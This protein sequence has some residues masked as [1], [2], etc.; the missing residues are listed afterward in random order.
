MKKQLRFFLGLFIF[1]FL[2]LLLITG[3]QAQSQYKAFYLLKPPG[4]CTEPPIITCPSDF[5]SCLTADDTA[6]GNL[7]HKT[8]VL[9]YMNNS[10]DE[11][12]LSF[13]KA[14]LIREKKITDSVEPLLNT[15]N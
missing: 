11:A 8:G 3:I 2:F 9:Y 12:I 1:H 10:Y 14:L 15:L 5:N 13:R 7:Y 6:F 4:S